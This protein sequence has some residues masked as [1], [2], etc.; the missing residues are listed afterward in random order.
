MVFTAAAAALIVAGC[1]QTAPQPQMAAS[2]APAINTSMPSK[3]EQ[4]CLRSV[5]T[6]TAN[7]DVVLL[8]GT[9]TSQANNTVYVGVGP[10][11]AKWRCLVKNGIVADVMSLTDEGKL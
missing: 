6:T 1:V 4:A 8:Q 2:T 5:S 3:D 11:R 7:G 9:E 10:N